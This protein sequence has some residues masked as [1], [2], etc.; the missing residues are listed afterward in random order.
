MLVSFN[1]IISLR[2]KTER[3]QK[4]K[5]KQEQPQQQQITCNRNAS[6]VKNKFCFFR[7]CT[8]FVNLVNCYDHI[9]LEFLKSEP[10]IQ[11]ELKISVTMENSHDLLWPQDNPLSHSSEQFH[12]LRRILFEIGLSLTLTKYFF[13]LNS[14]STYSMRYSGETQGK[15]RSKSHQLKTQSIQS[16]IEFSIFPLNFV[17][18][19]RTY[20]THK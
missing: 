4:K 20:M 2:R 1:A 16:S 6:N 9:F 19:F 18:F 17:F 14:S 15:Q 12:D 13:L 8:Q 11:N 5:T 7:I 3:E 10:Q